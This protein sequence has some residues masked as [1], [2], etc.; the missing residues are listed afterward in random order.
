MTVTRAFL[1]LSAVAGATTLTPEAFAQHRP[2]A[3]A[4]A[5][6]QPA[7]RWSDDYWPASALEGV[8]VR[9]R[10]G[11]HVGVVT[12]ILIAKDGRAAARIDASRYLGVGRT[13]VIPLDAIS[14]SK[15]G[16]EPSRTLS[17]FAPT[18]RTG[19]ARLADPERASRNAPPAAVAP[20]TRAAVNRTQDTLVP[21]SVNAPPVTN[22]RP[23]PRGAAA[24]ADVRARATDASYV[25]APRR[26]F[27]WDSPDTA[28]INLGH[29]EIMRMSRMR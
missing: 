25:R 6:E 22:R 28:T 14:F 23:D 10:D 8:N 20:T 7:G 3:G 21:A 29:D 1:I 27:V 2:P 15:S 26:L 13:L 5:I 11:E 9:A 17:R 12:N 19:G 4:G 16:D 24:M 18:D